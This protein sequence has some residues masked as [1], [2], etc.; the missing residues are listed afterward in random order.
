MIDEMIKKCELFSNT[1]N[2]NLVLKSLLSDDFFEFCHFDIPSFLKD[3]DKN[4]IKEII[5]SDDASDKITIYTNQLKLTYLYYC[6]KKDLS[7]PFFICFG[8]FINSTI[9][10]D[11]IKYIAYRLKLSLEN[12]KQLEYFYSYV[13]FHENDKIISIFKVLLALIRSS[14]AD[15]EC[16][17]INDSEPLKRVQPIESKYQHY[18]FV[19]A[20]YKLETEL[21]LL[22]EK[23]SIEG[24]KQYLKQATH[25]IFPSRQP[26]DPLR[27]A[28]NMMIILNSIVARAARKGGLSPHIVYSISSKYTAEIEKQI[29]IDALT[30]LRHTLII[31]YCENVNQFSLDQYSVLIRNAIHIIRNNLYD[32]ITLKDIANALHVSE[33]HLSRLF[34][35]E[36]GVNITDYINTLKIK[37]SLS[38]LES[39][40]YSIDQIAGIFDFCNS[41]YYCTV[42][43]KIIGVSPRDY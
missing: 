33:P 12:I 28:K 8:P 30:K 1:Q 24:L 14:T 34:H 37:E 39:K 6:Q 41:S 31:D 19:E 17:Y 9:S 11:E 25:I 5:N 43:K 7:L 16:H 3:Y 29:S 20:N 36:T 40:N 10:V 27:N 32:H 2:T 15:I 22:I 18:D 21:L 4:K 42:F 35:K 38:F 26:H 13:P 23:G